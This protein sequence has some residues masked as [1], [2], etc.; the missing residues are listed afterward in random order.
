[1][2]NTRNYIFGEVFEIKRIHFI[3][4]LFWVLNHFDIHGGFIVKTYLSCVIHS[5][6]NYTYFIFYENAQT[7]EKTSCVP[8]Y[9]PCI[10]PFLLHIVHLVAIIQKIHRSF[11]VCLLLLIRLSI[12][13]CKKCNKIYASTKIKKI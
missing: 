1:M 11:L 5:R 7:N 4:N 12:N 9:I 13:T 3:P 6:H 10:K 2:T 8:L